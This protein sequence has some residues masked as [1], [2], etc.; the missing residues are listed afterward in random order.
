MLCAVIKHAGVC[1]SVVSCTH[2]QVTVLYAFIKYF[3]VL[4]CAS[5]QRISLSSDIDMLQMFDQSENL[6][7]LRYFRIQNKCINKLKILTLV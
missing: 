5:M 1:Q 6:L 4:K 2:T 7:Y 3:E